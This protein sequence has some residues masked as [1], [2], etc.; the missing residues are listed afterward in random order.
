L[1]TASGRMR[2]TDMEIRCCLG[3]IS[4]ASA[5]EAGGT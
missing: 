3:L 2:I 4:G 1:A 5:P